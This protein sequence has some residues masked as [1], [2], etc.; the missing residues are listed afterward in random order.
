MEA[1]TVDDIPLIKPGDDIAAMI[2]ERAGLEDG[3]VLVIAS[4]I[5]A[6]AENE[7]FS[8][9]GITPSDRAIGIGKNDDK[10]PRLVQAV[11]DRCSEC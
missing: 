5:I 11:L 4:T 9:E 1:F 3:D 10:D 8:L 7:L 6:K 2:C